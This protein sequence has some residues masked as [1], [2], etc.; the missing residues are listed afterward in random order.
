[1]NQLGQEKLKCRLCGSLDLS[2]VKK[3]NPNTKL[4]SL[5]FAITDSNYGET[6][7]L[8]RCGDCGLLE[9]LK[10]ENIKEYYVNLE[11]FGYEA[12]RQERLLQA[13]KILE[14]LKKYLSF[15]KILDVGAGSG[16][17]VEE[18]I[19]AGY[20][21]IGLE[22]SSWLQ[23][24]ATERG[25]PVLTG[26]LPNVGVGNSYD[27]VMLID[28]I[29]HVDDP[30]G[31]LLEIKKIIKTDGLLILTTPD[32]NSFFA[33]VLRWRWWH[34]RIAHIS[35]FNLKTLKLLFS[36]TGFEIVVLRRPGWYFSLDYLFERIKKYLPVF[37]H[38][39]SPPFFKKIVIP[40][41]LFDS[42]EIICRLNK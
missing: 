10:T 28:V 1:M 20:N 40:L 6:L 19:K 31:L 16:I 9:N 29:E 27:A 17:L 23:K 33:N 39:K 7:D 38:F 14:N 5:N 24:K 12:S 26:V 15:G 34:F 32:L 35:Y 42:Y 21:A 3:S 11:D 13:K 8:Y 25:L 22:P 36:K 18:A 4:N 41:N 37:L 2:L 30:I